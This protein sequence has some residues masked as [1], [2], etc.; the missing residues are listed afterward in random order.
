MARDVISLALRRMVIAR[1]RQRCEYCLLPDSHTT[2]PHHVD[3]VIPLKHGGLTIETNLAYACFEC[4]LY[5]GADIA[6]FDPLD[7]QMTRLFNPR[8]DVWGDSFK[9]EGGRIV[10][11]DALGRAIVVLLRMNEE[12]R[13]LQRQL[14]MT[15]G[16]F[17]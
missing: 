5:K 9:L 17:G 1:A 3:H 14:L 2:A 16:I 4:N 6:A 12:W 7:G 13:V 10:G 15:A 8:L 11:L